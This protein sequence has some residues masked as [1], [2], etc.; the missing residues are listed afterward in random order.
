MMVF[1]TPPGLTR[2]LDSPSLLLTLEPEAA[3]VAAAVA[4]AA[5]QAAEAAA[6]A[7]SAEALPRT[8][9]RRWLGWE[10]RQEQ[11]QHDR[12]SADDGMPLLRRV[13]GGP[14]GASPSSPS[15]CLCPGDT[16][17]VV[18]CG[19]GTVDV[20]MHSV[21][22]GG[23]G[24][25]GMGLRLADAAVGKGKSRPASA[26]ATPSWH[27]LQRNEIAVLVANLTKTYADI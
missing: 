19:G 14:A 17:L 1:A 24:A 8:A 20:T 12:S 18:D 2:T 6:P 5:Q 16:L 11:Q 26:L 21:M 23:D 15:P 9:I 13:G 4:G 7:G 27:A 22:A 10:P 3:A 25:A